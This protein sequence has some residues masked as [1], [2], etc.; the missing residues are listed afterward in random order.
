MNQEEFYDSMHNDLIPLYAEGEKYRNLTEKEYEKDPKSEEGDKYSYL[1]DLCYSKI[2]E[3]KPIHH[4]PYY[5]TIQLMSTEELDRELIDALEPEAQ[6]YQSNLDEEIKN[7][8]ELEKEYENLEKKKYGFWQI[9]KKKERVVKLLKLESDI[10]YSENMINQW[11]SKLEK[12]HNKQEAFRNSSLE[13]LTK[14]LFKEKYGYWGELIFPTILEEM[15]NPMVH[16]V[17]QIGQDYQKAKKLAALLDQYYAVENKKEIETEIIAEIQELVGPEIIIKEIP[18]WDHTELSS[19]EYIQKCVG[20]AY[21]DKVIKET[22]QKAKQLREAI[23]DE[24]LEQMTKE[25]N[26]EEEN[27]KSYK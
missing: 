10:N 17:A 12:V 16:S 4:F 26:K 19:L 13:E 2:A 1:S 25:A 23:P 5:F 7:K 14:A 8:K 20:L 27:K 15:N 21:R 18:T 24:V 22:Y 6:K 3:V 11:E 9:K